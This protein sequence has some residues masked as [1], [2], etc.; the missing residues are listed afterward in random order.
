MTTLTN[1]A[2][3]RLYENQIKILRAE[4]DAAF[5]RGELEQQKEARIKILEDI[6]ATIKLLY[7]L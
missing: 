5:Q 2:I 6:I 3:I 1:E 4:I 7:N